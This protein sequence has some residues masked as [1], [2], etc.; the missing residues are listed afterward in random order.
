MRLRGRY[1]VLAGLFALA[2]VPFLPVR[3]PYSVDT[4]GTVFPARRWALTRGGDDLLVA[5]VFD[6]ATGM[7][8]EYRASQF[9]R[10]ESVRID[11]DPGLLVGAR[12]LEGDTIASISSTEMAP[13]MIKQTAR[14]KTAINATTAVI[15]FIAVPS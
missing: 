3:I 13:R 7:T 14:V 1:C 15:F 5:S 8:D 9:E 10:G 11:M 2:A 4:V 12:V 6:Y